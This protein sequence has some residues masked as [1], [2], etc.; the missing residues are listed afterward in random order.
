MLAVS[1]HPTPVKGRSTASPPATD[2][3]WRT[4]GSH[5]EIGG[6]PRTALREDEIG[7]WD[8]LWNLLIH[9]EGQDWIP[10]GNGKDRVVDED[11]RAR[12]LDR[13]EIGEC[14][15]PSGHLDPVRP[16][17]PGGRGHRPRGPP[18]GQRPPTTPV[19]RVA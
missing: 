14:E 6:D 5:L 13:V 16:G 19:S 4:H 11:V 15:C 8:R 7:P 10:I 18:G 1:V 3:E 2:D 9:R 12:R 17:S